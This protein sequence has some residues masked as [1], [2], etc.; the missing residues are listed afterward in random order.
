MPVDFILKFQTEF[1]EWRL[2]G[3]DV[4]HKT[5]SNVLA[6]R[7]LF[8]VP[9]EEYVPKEKENV[10]EQKREKKETKTLW[11]STFTKGE[12]KTEILQNHQN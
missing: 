12:S 11:E 1:H 9:H 5:L 2:A 3:L 10:G 8:E 6:R 4:G 7:G